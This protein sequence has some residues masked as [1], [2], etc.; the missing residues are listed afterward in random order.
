MTEFWHFLVLTLEIFILVAFLIVLVQIIGDVF[1]DHKLG[2]FAKAI[3]IVVLIVFP[4]VG[5]LIYLIARGKGMTE[6]RRAQVEA[7]QAQTADYI[8]STARAG[9]AT[10]LAA[11]KDLLDNGTLTQAEFDKIKAQ[12]VGV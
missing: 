9:S 8:R 12:V 2:G 7:A 3:W 4:V 5:S 11:A 10:E 6:R 1:A